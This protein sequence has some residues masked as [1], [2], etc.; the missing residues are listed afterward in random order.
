MARDPY[1]DDSDGRSSPSSTSSGS[2]ASALTK[3]IGPLPAWGW[4]AVL[5]AGILIWRK[6]GGGKAGGAGAAQQ[7]ANATGATAPAYPAGGGSVY[8]LPGA[9]APGGTGTTPAPATGAI[10]TTIYPIS[11]PGQAPPGSACP[12]GYVL[13]QGPNG[14]TCETAAQSIQLGKY[15]QAIGP[16]P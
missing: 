14:Y 4:A 15:L 6:I 2:P 11:G 12:S 10:L 16:Q 13:V 7:A 8:L 5:V 9:A 3:P 1:E